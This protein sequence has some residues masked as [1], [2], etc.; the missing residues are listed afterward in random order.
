[1]FAKHS[2]VTIANNNHILNYSRKLLSFI[3]ILR[4]QFNPKLNV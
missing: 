2:E 4:I 3:E 1:M